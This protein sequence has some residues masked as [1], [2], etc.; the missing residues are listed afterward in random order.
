MAEECDDGN[1]DNFDGCSSQCMVESYAVCAGEPSV[2]NITI[3]VSEVG[4]IVRKAGCNV[5]AIDVER[6]EL[7]LMDDG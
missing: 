7:G 4:L 5:L 1:T 2:C 3:G 6:E